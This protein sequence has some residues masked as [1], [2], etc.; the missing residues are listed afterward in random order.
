MSDIPIMKTLI[1]LG[2]VALALAGS[3]KAVVLTPS[4]S[5]LGDL[6]HHT[7]VTWGI[8]WNSIPAGQVI[9]GA[10]LKINN[11]WD[12]QVENDQLFIHLLNNPKTGVR[13]T[14]DNTNDNVISDYF[15]GQGILLTTFSDPA[16]GN[17]GQNATNFVYNFDVGQLAVL[18]NYVTDSKTWLG[19]ANGGWSADFGLGFDPDCHYFNT[20]VS[21][22][23]TTGPAETPG[24]PSVPD[25]GSTAALFLVGLTGLM[26]AKRRMRG[27]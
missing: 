2:C 24:V 6:D 20:G 13:S 16:G 19:W 3:A 11:L 10:T 27:K 7:A 15:S 4:P 17:N 1:R 23:I 9:T 14:V 21:L 25:A 5:D 18:N 22:T 26:A 8:T 12:W